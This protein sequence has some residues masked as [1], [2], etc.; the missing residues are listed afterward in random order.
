MN[1]L[2]KKILVS[3]G[4]IALCSGA[5]RAGQVHF[6]DTQSATHDNIFVPSACVASSHCI[7][8]TDFM[9]NPATGSYSYTYTSCTVLVVRK[10]YPGLLYQ[11]SANSPSPPPGPGQSTAVQSPTPSEAGEY[12]VYHI[13]NGSNNFRAEMVTD[14]GW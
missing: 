5:A 11:I 13:A 14:I 9:Y 2:I 12:I 3:L 8:Y 4:A 7:A 6:Y 10:F 1:M